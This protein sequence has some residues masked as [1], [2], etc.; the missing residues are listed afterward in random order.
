MAKSDV[1]EMAVPFLNEIKAMN[2]QTFI[3]CTPAFLGRDPQLLKSMSDLS[4]LNIITNTGYY[5]ARSN[6]FIP[7]HAF[8]ES[9]DQLAKRWIDEWENGIEGTGIKPGFIKIGVDNG[10]LSD[11]HKK[12][13]IAAARTHLAT[14]LVIASHTGPAVPAFEQIE[15]LREEGVSPQAFIWVHAQ[16]EKNFDKHT[17]AARMGTW[18]SFDGL[19]SEN[20]HD[21]FQMIKNM[22]ENN[23]LD[24]VLLSHDAGWYDPAKPNGGEF[25]GYSTLFTMLLPLLKNENFT[26]DEIN[27]L[28]VI[29]PGKAFEVKVRRIQ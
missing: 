1:I 23:L 29:N 7:G 12:L 5:G 13:I 21:Y 8:S 16:N 4:G 15:I 17:E 9:A 3:E 19:K 26:D 24:K 20:V 27:R 25:R 6:K 11:M 18:I 28:L 10:I 2:F 22:K 14:G